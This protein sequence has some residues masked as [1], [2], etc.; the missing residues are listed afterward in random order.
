MDTETPIETGL[1]LKEAVQE[2]PEGGI[3]GWA[4]ALGT[5]LIMFSTL[6]YVNSWGIL[7]SYYETHQLSEQ[8]PDQ[9]AWIGSLQSFF[10]FGGTLFGG[11]M[12]D[13]WGEKVIRPA[14]VA[15]VLSRMVTSFCQRY[16]QFLLAQGVFG[17]ISL[18]MTMSPSM[19]ATPQYFYKKRGTAMGIIMAGS[20]VSG[21]VWPIALSKML[22]NERLGFGWSLRIVGF[23]MLAVLALGATGIKARL[24]PRKSGFLLLR[25]FRDPVYCLNVT[26]SFFLFM[27]MFTPVFFLPG[28]ALAKGM[29][30]ELAGYL[31]AILNGASFIGRVVPGIL[32]D[33]FGRYNM[34]FGATLASGIITLCWTKCETSEDIIVFAVFFGF[35]SGALVSGASTTLASCP[36]DPKD[37]GTYMGMGLFLSSFAVLISPPINGALL[38]A[39]NDVLDVSIFSG[40]L[41][42]VGA[43]AVLLT[44]AFGPGGLWAKT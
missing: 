36:G 25:A 3:R 34:L 13:R 7:R 38:K 41:L 32:A 30:R 27:G 19:A 26:S 4:T 39:D 15:Y 11:P 43:V 8:S 28:Y 1:G 18:G 16:W 6:G 24:P 10:V 29:D 31:L 20:S 5:A 44:K 35:C 22:H 17:G 12:F 14:A 9:V 37:I 40:V 2:F 33:R 42:L 23:I 21:V